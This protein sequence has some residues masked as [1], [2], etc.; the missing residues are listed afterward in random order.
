M[1][2]ALR[3]TYEAVPSPK[4]VVAVGM[5]DAMLQARILPPKGPMVLGWHT[6]DPDAALDSTRLALTTVAGGVVATAAQVVVR[7]PPDWAKA[8]DR[9]IAE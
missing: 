9:A 4:L 1:R 2:Q 7:N 3:K 5:L 8:I 6:A